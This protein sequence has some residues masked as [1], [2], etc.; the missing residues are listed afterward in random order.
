MS[1]LSFS[2]ARELPF[3]C[4]LRL[5]DTY[6]STGFDIHIFVCI[7]TNLRHL[8]LI[9]AILAN[10]NENLMELEISELKSFLQRLPSMDMD[11][12][13]QFKNYAMTFYQIIS[14]AYNIRDE[15]KHSSSV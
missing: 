5:W 9:L 13:F 1:W 10:C 12:V 14:Q 15:L 8:K 2:L 6:F 11:E 7:G 4:V 3:E